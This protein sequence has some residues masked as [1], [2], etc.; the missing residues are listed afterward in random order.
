ML[1]FEGHAMATFGL[2]DAKPGQ[3]LSDAAVEVVAAAQWVA[4]ERA[5]E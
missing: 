1:P 5:R 2:H 3:R 4:P